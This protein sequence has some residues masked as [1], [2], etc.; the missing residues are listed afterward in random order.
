MTMRAGALL[1]IS[2]F[3]ACGCSDGVSSAVDAH[4]IDRVDGSPPGDVDASI[5]GIDGGSVDAANATD[6]GTIDRVDASSRDDASP[7]DVDACVARVFYA[8]LDGDHHGA[9]DDTVSSCEA[10]AG[11]VDVAGDCDDACPGCHPGADETCDGARDNDCDGA[12]DEECGCVIGETRDCGVSLGACRAGTQRCVDGAWGECRGAVAP[13]AEL[14]DGI[15]NDCDAAID[16]G[17][18]PSCAATAGAARMSCEAGAC[19]VAACA[20][21][22]GDCDGEGS[23]GCEDELDTDAHCGACGRACGVGYRCVASACAPDAPLGALT[24]SYGKATDTDD[25]AGYGHDVAVTRDGSRIAVRSAEYDSRWYCRI[26][27]WERAASGWEL[28]SSTRF[29]GCS[30]S[31]LQPMMFSAD[32]NVLTS[33]SSVSSFESTS[34]GTHVLRRSGDTW[35]ERDIAGHGV[36]SGDGRRLAIRPYSR[37]SRIDVY[38]WSEATSDWVMVTSVPITVEYYFET[39]LRLSD[40]ATLLLYADFRANRVDVLRWSG[41]T[42][43]LETRLTGTD[44]YDYFGAAI[45]ISADGQRIAIGA[46]GEDSAAEDVGGNPL[47]NALSESGAAYVY[48]RDGDGW[49]L[50][51]YVKSHSPDSGDRFGASLSLSP[52]GTTLVVGATYEDSAATGVD[53]GAEDDT[54]SN[55]GA[56]YVYDRTG[57]TWAYRSYLKS[58]AGDV[59]DELGSGIACSDRGRTIV[60]GVRR[61]D[62]S[63]SGW[64]ADPT[65]DRTSNAGAIFVYQR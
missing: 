17:A 23:N 49:E 25:S 55:A 21:G 33:S 43:E 3:V 39:A 41:T 31:S 12:V 14:C 6:G 51:A 5:P 65:D 18:G 38:D 64:D 30:H 27:L 8:D 19:V 59:D 62:G 36:M 7:S 4:A 42:Y 9:V 22:R 54:L 26:H 10:P 28:E 53:G 15:D 57:S 60:V 56:A 45:D 11:Y 13:S 47:S 20:E 34:W 32:G 2:M 24:A 48:V 63:G 46:W 16:D 58:L 61:E 35:S 37:T 40:D 29:G 1:T 52:D 44:T 50:E